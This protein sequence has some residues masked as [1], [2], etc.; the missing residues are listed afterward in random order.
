MNEKIYV[1]RIKGG[2]WALT[3]AD[4]SQQPKATFKHKIDAVLNAEAMVKREHVIIRNAEGQILQ[5]STIKTSRPESIMR[6]ALI[7]VIKARLK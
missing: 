5:H 2:K 7:S 4:K 1:E 3:T 6:N